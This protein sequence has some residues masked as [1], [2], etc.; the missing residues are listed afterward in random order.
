MGMSPSA[1]P[2]KFNH[3]RAQT[4][5][6][7]DVAAFLTGAVSYT[8][9]DKPEPWRLMKGSADIFKA[10]RMPILMGRSFSP[11]EDLPNGPRVA[12]ISQEVWKTRFAG[13]PRIVGRQISLNG[14]THTVVGV[15]AN[16]IGLME[17]GDAPTEVYVPF[18]IDPHSADLGNYFYVVCRLKPGVTLAQAQAGV[19]ASAAVYRAKYPKDL[20]PREGFI[21]ET[22]KEAAMGYTGFRSF[23]AVLLGAVT[24]VLLIVC[25]N[26]ANLLLARAA[27]RKREIGIRLAVGA[28]RTRIVRQLLAEST[29]LAVA[30]GTLG[31]LLGHAGIQY[32]GRALFAGAAAGGNRSPSATAPRTRRLADDTGRGNRARPAMVSSRRVVRPRPV[33]A[34]ARTRGGSGSRARYRCARGAANVPPAI[35]SGALVSAV[36]GADLLLKVR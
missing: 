31:L 23:L 5:V 16:S 12:V 10:W 22:L 4:S 2:V 15:A 36:A 34:G 7:E 29:L 17:F 14:D 28:A 1:S 11:E 18:Q 6:V 19:K 35:G 3:W 20:D 33:A 8:S 25:A 24:F 30:G 21:V 27:G 13:D 9:G 32:L 26:V